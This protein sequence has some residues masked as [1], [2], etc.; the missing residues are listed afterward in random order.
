MEDKNKN[1]RIKKQNKQKIKIGRVLLIFLI[2]ALVCAG[3]G[4]YAYYAS[5]EKRIVSFQ[6][7]DFENNISLIINDIEIEEYG[8]P[9]VEYGGKYYIHFDIVNGY[10]DE[11][12]YWDENTHK[13]IYTDL[14]NIIT[15]DIDITET[16]APIIYLEDYPMVSE[17][18]IEEL[19]DINFNF[20]ENT[21]IFNIETF[22]PSVTTVA[23]K[24][25]NYL[26]YEPVENSDF[27]MKLEQG[28][29]VYVYDEIE[30]YTKIKTSDG[31]I[32]YIDSEKL[33]KYTIV[34][35]IFEEVL[36]EPARSEKIILL[37]DQVT[38]VQANSNA[39]RRIT[40]QG[41]N[42]LS[43]T[44]FSYNENN[45]NGDI[46]S[47]ADKDYVDFA[48]NNGYEVWALLTDI[49]SYG[50]NVGNIGNQV[51]TNTEFRQNTINQLM[52]LIEKYDL[53]GINLDF[54]YVRASDIDDY[55]QFVRELYTEMKKGGYILSVDTY[56]P[57]A[58]SMYYNRKALAESSDYI[59]VMTY[60]E[61]TNANEAMGPVASLGFVEKGVEDTLNEVPADKLLMGIPFYTR[62]WKTEYT[63]DGAKNSL[64]NFGMLSA[65][66]FFEKNNAVIR[67]DEET[68][69]YYS[70]F[71]TTENGNQVYYQAWLETTETIEKK[72]EIYNKYDLAGLALWKRGLEDKDIWEIIDREK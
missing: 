3:I 36:Y 20:Y 4:L 68:G 30:S 53:D 66:D 47:L 40:H 24:Y 57:S 27:S 17:M 11:Y 45:L 12:L 63:D 46:I 69:Y 2:F 51:L 25:L 65:V 32:G 16:L 67:W 41:V 6:S 29:K 1:N 26:R 37:W 21:N 70:E 48:H 39:N 14:T 50:S 7:S 18:I 38:T 42:V 8:Q 71:T 22:E 5:L 15:Y 58:W 35:E 64:S 28:E 44:W 54:E 10:I 60:D 23:T 49:P 52:D 34:T 62:V 55:I 72:L 61:H 56:V 19:Y 9:V 33:D 59:A 43:P 31:I 13:V